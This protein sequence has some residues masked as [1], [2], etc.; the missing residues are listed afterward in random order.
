MWSSQGFNCTYETSSMARPK[1]VMYTVDFDDITQ[2]GS[3]VRSDFEEWSPPVPDL[4]L[5]GHN[6][7]YE[8]RKRD[9]ECFNSKTYERP[10]R[11]KICECSN[12]DVECEYGF[13]RSDYRAKCELIESISEERSCPAIEEGYKLSTTHMRKVH[14]DNCSHIHSIIPDYQEPRN[15]MHH[16]HGHSHFS[17]GKFLFVICIVTG[18]LAG[19]FFGWVK[20]FAADHVKDSVEE[21][22]SPI[23][24]CCGS[25]FGWL[26]DCIQGARGQLSS[27]SPSDAYFHPLA[28]EEGLNMDETETGGPLLVNPNSQAMH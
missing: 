12:E 17:F 28:G 25:T 22:C 4:C 5:L 11:S 26:L 18:V 24:S 9:A 15:H 27:S 21:A 8:R 10:V 16:H 3:C 14:G 20:F 2:W 7:T 19:L 6:F 23:T 1:G 13:F